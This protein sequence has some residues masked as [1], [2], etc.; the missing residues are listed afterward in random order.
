MAMAH[1]IVKLHGGETKI[2][3]SVG[4]GSCFTVILPKK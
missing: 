2:D 1:K 3:S 4:K